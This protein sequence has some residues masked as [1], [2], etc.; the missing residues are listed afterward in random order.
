MKGCGDDPNHVPPLSRY[1]LNI[2]L[3]CISEHLVFAAIISVSPYPQSP[4]DLS[5]AGTLQAMASDPALKSTMNLNFEFC[6]LEFR[7]QAAQGMNKM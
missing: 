6:D 3:K 4:F 7:G 5:R 1:A 2:F